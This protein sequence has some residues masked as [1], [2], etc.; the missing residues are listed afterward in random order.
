MNFDFCLNEANRARKIG[1]EAK[2]K[3]NQEII[4]HSFY[5]KIIYR[6]RRIIKNLLF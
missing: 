5:E 2:E 4:G 1:L 3:T 6:L